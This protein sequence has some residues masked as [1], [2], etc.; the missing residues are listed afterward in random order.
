MLKDVPAEQFGSL[1]DGGYEFSF[2][3]TDG[4]LQ[5]VRLYLSGKRKKFRFAQFDLWLS[6]F[7][8]KP[9]AGEKFREEILPSI[10]GAGK[11]PP[12]T[13]VVLPSG[14]GSTL[15][16]SIPRGQ[17]RI[18]LKRAASYLADPRN[19]YSVAPVFSQAS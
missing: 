16:F 13:V 5:T 7:N 12:G 8:V 9:A 2:L 15:T 10:D 11:I 3:P 18:W 19:L 1:Q 14:G 4:S 6:D 17:E